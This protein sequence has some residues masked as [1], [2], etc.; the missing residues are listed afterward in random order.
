M[1][2]AAARPDPVQ[3]H[4]DI[5]RAYRPSWLNGIFRAVDRL[6]G[7]PALFYGIAAVV[8]VAIGTILLWVDGTQPLGTVSYIRAI[9]D[10]YFV[11]PIAVIHYL[12]VAAGRAIDR[13]RPAFGPDQARFDLYRHKLTTVPR[14]P[15]WIALGVGIIYAALSFSSDPALF[16]VLP[17]SPAYSAIPL[18]TSTIVST[19]LFVVYLVFALRQLV[20]VVR[21]HRAADNLSLFDSFAH[22]AFSGLTLRSSILM[23]LPVYLFAFFALLSGRPAD[24]ISIPDLISVAAAISGAAL[25]FILPLLGMHRRLVDEKAQLLRDIWVRIGTTAQDLHK[26]MDASA[27]ERVDALNKQLSTLLLESET[28]KKLSTWPW[29][30]ETLRGFLT[31]V[32]LPILLW[33]ATT[34]LGKFVF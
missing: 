34:L 3:Q 9:N 22:N 4:D 8:A 20:Y 25:I 16:G 33:I 31:S 1:A 15:V 5:A 19:I 14:G 2:L 18:A 26:E 13:F 24:A 11:F 30:V 12:C 32:A 10:L 23:V 28:V 6:P 17:N 27:T 7:P 29:A 21:I